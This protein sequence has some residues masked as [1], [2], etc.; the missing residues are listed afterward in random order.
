[1]RTRFSLVTSGQI[2]GELL[3]YREEGT[4]KARDTAVVP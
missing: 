3:V 1:M 2:S 4:P